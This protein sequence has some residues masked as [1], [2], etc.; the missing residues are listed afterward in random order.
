[1]PTKN[2]I[3]NTALACIEDAQHTALAMTKRDIE[4]LNK[5]MRRGSKKPP[6]DRDAHGL[7][8]PRS[9]ATLRTIK[10]AL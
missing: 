8:E 6:G 7:P 9:H 2:S 10:E 4:R 1:M 5:R 3:A